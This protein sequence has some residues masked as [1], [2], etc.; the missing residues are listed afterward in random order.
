VTADDGV[1]RAVAV[2]S[3]VVTVTPV[4]DQPVAYSDTVET[5]EDTQVTINVLSNDFD[6]EGDTLVILEVTAPEHG[7]ITVEGDT[8]LF[9]MPD[10]NYAGVDSFQYIISDGDLSDT[11]MVFV[12]IN[13]KNDGPEIIEPIPVVELDEDEVDSVKISITELY[14]WVTDPDD[15]DSSLIYEIISGEHITVEYKV[16]SLAYYIYVP[17]DWYGVDSLMLKVSDGELADSAYMII[18]VSPVNDPP[19]FVEL[20]DTVKFYNTGEERLVLLDYVEDIDSPDSSLSFT[21]SV[22][23]DSLIWELD[24]ETSELILRATDFL[25]EVSIQIIVTDDSSAVASATIIA[26]VEADPSGIEGLTSEVPDR[27][28]LE[29]N[30]PNPFN[31]VTHIRF[32]LPKASDVLIEVYNI[33]GQRVSVI[34]NKH[35][36]AGYHV[37]EFNAQNL[38]SGFYLYRIKAEGFQQ[39]KKMLLLK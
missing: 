27:Y 37:V 21:I 34:L 8:V 11:A 36:V 28:I 10:S 23:N 12:T 20:P 5:D 31:P 4:N 9:Y 14:T 13:S 22:D 6:V 33:V 30:Y 7:K 16:D 2:D 32:G 1:N 17:S 38:P 35:M 24:E 19:R 25:G 15:A 29:Q 39:V 3:F 18:N 26:K